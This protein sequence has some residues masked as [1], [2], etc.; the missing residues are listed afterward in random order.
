MDNVNDSSQNWKTHFAAYVSTTPLPKA[1]IL[2]ALNMHTI[3][4]S[5]YPQVS[6]SLNHLLVTSHPFVL[7]LFQVQS[8]LLSEPTFPATIES[9][10]KPKSH[11]NVP[12]LKI[13]G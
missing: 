2:P 12:L 10:L 7:L 5:L 3:P 11:S 13:K 4:T 1:N 6:L 9:G 8:Y